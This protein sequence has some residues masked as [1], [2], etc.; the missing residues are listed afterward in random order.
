MSE[1]IGLLLGGIA[2]TQA[3]SKLLI[4]LLLKSQPELAVSKIAES[5]F[6]KN[7]QPPNLPKSRRD[8]SA[9]CKRFSDKCYSYDYLSRSLMQVRVF[10][11]EKV[12]YFAAT[13]QSGKAFK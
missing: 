9:S 3:A 12:A 7:H 6:L 5:G 1:M 13:L 8:N 10:Y 11:N 4:I 2:I